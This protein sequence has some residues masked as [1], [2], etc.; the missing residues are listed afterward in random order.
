MLKSFLAFTFVF[1]RL[2]LLNSASLDDSE[3]GTQER[4]P[5]C[6]RTCQKLD[7]V[8][9]VVV[10]FVLHSSWSMESLVK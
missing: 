7:F 8:V 2:F 9:A 6:I 1:P 10:V 5:V 4:A 3:E